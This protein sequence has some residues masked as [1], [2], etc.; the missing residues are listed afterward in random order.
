MEQTPETPVV[1]TTKRRRGRPPKSDKAL[2]PEKNV[3]SY[4]R[5]RLT[6]LPDP[7]LKAKLDAL[8][9]IHSTNFKG[10]VELAVDRLA[11]ELT[12]AQKSIYDG[13]V[14]LRAG[15]IK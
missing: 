9:F 14:K 6:M 12:P 7:S 8:C 4:L 3:R 5:D 13:M 11:H 15:E 2:T 10:L 1:E